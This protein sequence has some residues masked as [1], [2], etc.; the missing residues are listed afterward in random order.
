MNQTII[1]ITKVSGSKSTNVVKHFFPC[2]MRCTIWCKMSQWRLIQATASCL[3]DNKPLP[4]LMWTLAI[5][6]SVTKFSDIW[7][8]ILIFSMRK[9][10]F[11]LLS[12]KWKPFCSGM[13][14]LIHRGRVT[15]I[16]VDKLTIIGPDNGLSPGQR[17]A[18]IRTNAGML[19]IE[20]LRTN[21][22]GISIEIHTFSFQEM[23]LKMLSGKWRPFLSRP[24]CVK[25]LYS[26]LSGYWK[27]GVGNT[28]PISSD[29]LFSWFCRI[30]TSNGSYWISDLYFT[31]SLQLSCSA[32]CQIWM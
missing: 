13:N 3:T 30:F 10:D 25:M 20:P 31:G 26:V 14:V 24:Q 28:K 23:Y 22:S 21:F 1:D 19:L 9:M 7:I 11:E 17:Q 8:T 6:P 32:I 27:P 2:I 29:Q 15:H 16:C 5:E 12:T 18:I 4:K